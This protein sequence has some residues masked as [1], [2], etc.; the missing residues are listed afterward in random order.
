MTLNRDIMID[1]PATRRLRRLAP[2][3]LL[4]ALA[5]LIMAPGIITELGDNAASGATARAALSQLPR[6]QL[7]ALAWLR[8][9][10]C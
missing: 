8:R 3:I 7:P 2:L 5:A 4:L 10:A 6:F 1:P 9:H